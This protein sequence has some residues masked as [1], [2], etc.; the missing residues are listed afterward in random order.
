[1]RVY[2]GCARAYIGDVEGSNIIKLNSQ[3]PK[4]SYLAYPQFD[5]DPHP[6][7]MGSL[8]VSLDTLHVG[9]YDYVDSDNPPILHRKEEFVPEDYPTRSKFERLTRQEERWGLFDTPE[10]IGTL[11]GW[12]EVLRDKGVRIIGHRLLGKG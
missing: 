7:L 6:A 9:Y 11:K 4:V 5:R 12:Q 1:L 10:L 3:K 2:E 8:V